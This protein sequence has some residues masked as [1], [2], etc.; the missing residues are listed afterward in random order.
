MFHYF[1]HHNNCVVYSRKQFSA[2]PK[3]PHER[4]E[5]FILRIHLQRLTIIT[6]GKA[7]K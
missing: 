1:L 2:E 3:I 4:I 5:Q 7:I 6:V